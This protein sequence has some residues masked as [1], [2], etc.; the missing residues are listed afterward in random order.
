MGSRIEN[1][2]YSSP[3]EE[4][5]QLRQE[6]KQ[7]HELKEENRQLREEIAS[8]KTTVSAV[9]ARGIGAKKDTSSSNHNDNKNRKPGRKN[10]HEGRSRR[11]PKHIDA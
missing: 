10:G 1:W 4:N 3:K 8:L 6:N 5:K 9:V 11:K 7:L 2:I